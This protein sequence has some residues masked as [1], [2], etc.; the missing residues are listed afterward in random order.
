MQAK[1]EYEAAPEDFKWW[2][3]MDWWMGFTIFGAPAGRL[4]NLD[5]DSILLQPPMIITIS[6]TEPLPSQTGP[7]GMLS[8]V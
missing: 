2:S 1:I 4:F 3:E 6:P 7:K 8:R 5:V